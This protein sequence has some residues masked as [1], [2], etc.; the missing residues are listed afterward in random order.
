MA[1]FLDKHDFFEI[2]PAE[3]AQIYLKGSGIQEEFGCWVLAYWFDQKRKTT[4]CLI[5][6]PNLESVQEMHCHLYHSYSSQIFQVEQDLIESFLKC[7]ECPTLNPGRPNSQLLF[8]EK[9]E[10][11]AVM[12]MKLYC[13]N[14]FLKKEHT[15]KCFEDFK[16][17]SQSLV[18][19]NNGRIVNC[20]WECY[21]YSFDSIFQAIN[22]A[23]Q[24]R[25]ELDVL[26]KRKGDK[27]CIL[28]IGIAGE[29]QMNEKG[30]PYEETHNLARRLCCVASTNQIVISSLAKE[31]IQLNDVSSLMK[32]FNVKSLSFKDEQFLSKMMDYL[33]L[34]FREDLKIGNFCKI[35][36]ESRSQLY[37]KILE[38]TNL[39]PLAFIN[40]F[41]LKRATELMNMK[42]GNN[43]SQ[44]AFEAGF[45]N[46]SYFS[47]RFKKRFGVVPST[48]V[49]K[50]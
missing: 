34:N 46:L 26:L 39:P 3:I 30:D 43:I 36:G 27:T 50:N 9:S 45:N 48:Y 15:K 5:D 20:A 42:R 28:N 24:I 47:R 6:A 37:R 12:V 41:R 1:V 17:S 2:T 13:C 40:E 22:S 16:L 10:F 35:M 4:F 25:Q 8:S 7:I 29:K 44:I 14:T 19:K 33:E 49:N 31:Q 23:L 18:K 32:N 21:I 11:Y 38:V